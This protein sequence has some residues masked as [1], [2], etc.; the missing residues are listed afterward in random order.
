MLDKL[1]NT[2][3]FQ[4]GLL[5]DILDSQ[6]IYKKDLEEARKKISP[7]IIQKTYDNCYKD[8]DSKKA[9]K[10]Y[11]LFKIEPEA[12]TRLKK[13]EQKKL[14]ELP[15]RFEF[16]YNPNKP[17]FFKENLHTLD[18]ILLRYKP[19][20]KGGPSSKPV[21]SGVDFYKKLLEEY[22]FQKGYNYSGTITLYQD[23]NILRKPISEPYLPETITLDS[24]PL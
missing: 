12:K 13:F 11:D 15:I 14:I 16:P 18:D 19:I 10:L 7:E 20:F 24:K 22:P 4:Q 23:N 3:N 9:R 21:F 6:K 2:K 5:E 17:K 1:L 8:K